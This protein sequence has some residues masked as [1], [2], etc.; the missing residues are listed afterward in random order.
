MLNEIPKFLKEPTTHI[1]CIN[2][3]SEKDLE[4][5]LTETFSEELE[6]KLSEIEKSIFKIGEEFS[7]RNAEKEFGLSDCI[8]ELFKKFIIISHYRTLLHRGTNKETLEKDLNVLLNTE[9]LKDIKTDSNIL[10]FYINQIDCGYLNFWFAPEDLEF[11]FSDSSFN[12]SP[13]YFTGG[14]LTYLQ[15]ILK[16]TRTSEIK[17]IID[18]IDYFP[19]NYLIIPIHKKVLLVLNSPFMKL[20]SKKYNLR[21]PFSIFTITYSGMIDER[22]EEPKEDSL[23]ILST[24][25]FKKHILDPMEVYYNNQLILDNS[26]KFIGYGTTKKVQ[27]SVNYYNALICKEKNFLLPPEN[28]N[29]I[30]KSAILKD[31]GKFLNYYNLFYEN[32]NG[33]IKC[34]EMVSHDDNIQTQKDLKDKPSQAVVLFIFNENHDKIL[35]NKEFRMA[36]GDYIWGSVAGLVENNESYKDAAKR[37]LK[38]ET[39]LELINIL[40][41]LSPSYTATGVSNEKSICI[42]CEAKGTIDNSKEEIDEDIEP[43]WLS[44]EDVK[45]ILNNAE[46]IAART[47]MFCYMWL[48]SLNF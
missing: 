2:S 8:Y 42:F 35:L 3:H 38:E 10:N 12:Y 24:K 25:T 48:N 34:Y 1:Y 19:Q 22:F 37:E 18:T 39:G 27:S 6:E 47:Q 9:N 14:K 16:N 45:Q 17:N 13:D 20:Y 21:P 15:Q 40:D 33:D 11:I 44:K 29:L 31:R 26:I 30:F 7:E 43:K 46:P 28:K 41:T 36:T 32:K 5:I 23:G 4:T